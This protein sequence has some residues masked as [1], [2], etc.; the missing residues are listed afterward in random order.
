MKQVTKQQALERRRLQAGRWLLKGVKQAEV[1]RRLKVR[2]SAVSAW[3]KRLRAGGL[4]ALKST[5]ALGRPVGL[6]DVQRAALAAALKQGALAQG[7]ATELW[8]LPRV[9]QLI[10][11]RFGRRYCDSQVWRILR[12]MGF[13]PQRPGRR[14][15]ERDGPAI[16]VWKRQRWPRLK[17]TPPAKG[18]PSSS[19]TS[20]V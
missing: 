13:S 11:R 19:S 3:A 9:G 20:P 5:A 4:P 18:A 10:E 15:L 1:A 8:T 7:L 16:Q 2:P 12:A 17:K 6:S 14:A